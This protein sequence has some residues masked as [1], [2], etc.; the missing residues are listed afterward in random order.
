MPTSQKTLVLTPRA[1]KAMESYRW[2]GNVGTGKPNPACGNHGGKRENYA[3]DL[4]TS[5][6]PKAKGTDW[7][8]RD[9]TWSGR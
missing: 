1:T 9:S 7:G 5:E 6:I 3:E 8:K 2:P 4:E